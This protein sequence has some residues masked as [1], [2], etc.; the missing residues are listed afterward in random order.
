MAHDAY[1]TLIERDSA[2][3]DGILGV[4]PRDI[5]KEW[6]ARFHQARNKVL[7]HYSYDDALHFLTQYMRDVDA[8]YESDCEFLYMTFIPTEIGPEIEVLALIK[9]AVDAY[10]AAKTK[11]KLAAL[12]ILLGPDTLREASKQDRALRRIK[13]PAKF[14]AQVDRW[15]DIVATLI[16]GETIEFKTKG[17]TKIY[18][19]VEMGFENSR[20]KR[21]DEAWCALCAVARLGGEIT[22]A[23][24]VDMKDRHGLKDRVREISDRLRAM[25][26]AP[27]YPF[28]AYRYTNEEK[29]RPSYKLKI[30]LTDSRPWMDQPFGGS[31]SEIPPLDDFEDIEDYEEVEDLDDD[32]E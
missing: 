32:Y 27:G 9:K 18:N 17:V 8:I 16:D 29:P 20:T 6:H 12:S 21:P 10:N 2:P 28:H 5:P 13:T 24:S 11:K 23:D 22:W 19:F 14:P 1:D 31:E 7:H 4:L 26:D 30:H 3:Y 25:F 15:E